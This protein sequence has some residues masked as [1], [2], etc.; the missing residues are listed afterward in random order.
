MSVQYNPFDPAQVD[1]HFETLA[2][3]RREAPVA[4]VMPG[5]FY[6]SRHEDIVEVSRDYKTF[7]QGGFRPLE[8]DDR[9]PDEMELGET[10]PPF[11]TAVRKNL[12][13]VLSPPRV[14][15]YEPMVQAVCAD[16]V[17]AFADS[18]KVDLIAEYG[19]PLP[20]QVIGRLSGIPE[21]D[22]S[23][24]RAYSDDFI[25]AGTAAG[26]DEGAAAAARCL[27]FDQHLRQVI[28][29]RR[30]SGERPD[31]LM[32]ALIQCID[33][34][35]QP[36]SDER[37]LTHLSKDI[38]V[39]GVETTTHLIGNLFSEVLSQ[40][41]LY[42]RLREDRSLV[43][44]AVEESLRHLAPVQVLFR[45]TTTD[46]VVHGT[47][48]PADSVVVL[49]LASAN[50][51]EAVFDHAEVYDVDRPDVT[52]RHLGF[53][54]GIHLCVGAPLARLEGVC[55]LNAVFDRIP[56]MALASDFSYR[57]VPFFMMRGPVSLDVTFP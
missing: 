51:D 55:A 27:E 39:G 16:L 41:G 9:T 19:A 29:E 12:G 47:T 52:R 17:E 50:R 57:R 7:R 36:I 25:F 6:L 49:G 4:E 48:I 31:D 45:R 11:H 15:A 21:A 10:D 30:R 56:S 44:A 40:P 34:Q 5:V 13:A 22:L 14:R 33:D 37:V 53:N 28:S 23:L 26:T 20:A 1:D 54:W 35:G 3:L 8:E 2:A 43:P 42:Q 38:L 32:T 18:G 46:A 24:V